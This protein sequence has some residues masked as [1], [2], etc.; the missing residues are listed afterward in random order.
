MRWWKKGKFECG[1]W[2]IF[3]SVFSHWCSKNSWSLWHDEKWLPCENLRGPG[4]PFTHHFFS[5]HQ[6]FLVESWHCMSTLKKQYSLHSIGKKITKSFR[7]MGLIDQ[8]MQLCKK[9][10]HKFR[11]WTWFQPTLE[12]LFNVG[13]IPSP[14]SLASSNF[15]MPVKRV[16]RLVLASATATLN[17]E[18]ANRNG[19]VDDQHRPAPW[20]SF[21]S[22]LWTW[23]WRPSKWDPPPHKWK[24]GNQN[25]QKPTSNVGQKLQNSN[26]F[27]GL[28]YQKSCQDF[29]LKTSGHWRLFDNETCAFST[30]LKSVL[31][32]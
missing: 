32:F 20:A 12:T 9:S 22:Q 23:P 13:E 17:C 19:R 11:F 31:F 8:P 10:C 28:N 1:F 27:K 29:N 7:P 16:T 25:A 5:T 24:P 26:F 2:L 14:A 30:S 18:G 4:S 21:P 3:C 6:H 15:G